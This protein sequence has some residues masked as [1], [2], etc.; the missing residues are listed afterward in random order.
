M[1]NHTLTSNLSRNRLQMRIESTELLNL[2]ITST[3][4]EL[5]QLV[6]DNWTQ[7][8]YSSVKEPAPGISKSL[9]S[10]PGY[11]RRSPFVPFA[12]KNETG[13]LLKFTMMTSELDEL[14]EYKSAKKEHK[15]Y[16]VEH[17]K[18]VPFSFKSRGNWYILKLLIGKTRFVIFFLGK[19]R[20][21]DSHKLRMHR[22][23]VQ[24][25][26]YETV[27]LVTIDKVGVYFRNA[28]PSIQNKVSLIL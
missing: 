19:I 23:G 9:N 10:S 26:G 14:Y 6:R 15:W 4:I 13:S 17:G 22:L 20:H 18:T 3:L 16:R 24:V 21:S 5:Y 25:E 28:V 7:D 1:W 2:N 11:R 27:T 12:I 8:F